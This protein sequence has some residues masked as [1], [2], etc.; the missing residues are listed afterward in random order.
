[1]PGPACSLLIAALSAAVVEAAVGAN[2]EVAAGRAP[3]DVDGDEENSLT[4][5]LVPGAGLR[6]RSSTASLLLSYT[7]RIFYRLPNALGVDRPL[8]LHQ[9]GADHAQ[10]LTGRLD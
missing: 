1:M 6:L 7:P 5:T 8:V 4:F 2:G 9:V 10:E 3:V